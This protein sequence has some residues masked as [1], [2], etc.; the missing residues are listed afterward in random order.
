MKDERLQLRLD[1]ITR[2]LLD[3]LARRQKMN[4]SEWIRN[5]ILEYTGL[6]KDA[7]T[8][9]NHAEQLVKMEKYIDQMEELLKRYEE[10]PKLTELFERYKGQ[11]VEGTLIRH[12][13]DLV[14][15]MANQTMVELSK[16]TDDTDTKELLPT[17]QLKAIV[18]SPVSQSPLLEEVPTSPSASGWLQGYWIWL[19]GIAMLMGVVFL[20]R[21]TTTMGKSLKND[22]QLSASKDSAG[23][24]VRSF[25]RQSIA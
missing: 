14:H 22:E 25:G 20:W 21:W 2:N 9:K 6:K 17:V 13:A 18:P 23:T 7:S 10:Q 4:V 5:V 15:L 11:I 8:A 16:E 3:E 1:G 12:K 19:L 24:V